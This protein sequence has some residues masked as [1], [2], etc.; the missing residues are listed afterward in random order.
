MCVYTLR[1]YTGLKWSSVDQPRGV[2]DLSPGGE[3]AALSVNGCVRSCD[4]AVLGTVSNWAG[5]SQ[6]I[7]YR[8]QNRWFRMENPRNGWCSRVPPFIW[9]P[10]CSMVIIRHPRISNTCPIYGL[11]KR[12]QMKGF[13]K[14]P[15]VLHKINQHR[16]Q[17]PDGTGLIPNDHPMEHSVYSISE[18]WAMYRN[19][20]NFRHTTGKWCRGWWLV[21]SES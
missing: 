14:K 11:P 4:V 21:R 20:L 2:G 9:K 10:P 15:G 18:T 1:Y 13:G 5:A 8:A 16:W 17:Q 12:R 3:F 19:C 7:P 6:E